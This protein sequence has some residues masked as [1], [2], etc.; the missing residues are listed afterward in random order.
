MPY[1]N[2]YFT[3]FRK[4]ADFGGRA[5]R[6][7]YWFFTLF[8]VLVSIGLGAVDGALFGYSTRLENGPVSLAYVLVS[9]VPVISVTTRRLHDT[10]R[11]GWFQLI[12]LIPV[13]GWVILTVFTCFDS[14]VGE[15]RFGDDP[16]AGDREVQHA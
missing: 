5:S 14:Q 6:S 15:N 7:E 3:V 4:Y 1:L 2:W 10:D 11:S 13:I 9:L 12:T 16:K 8:H